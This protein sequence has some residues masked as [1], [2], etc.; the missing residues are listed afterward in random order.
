MKSYQ[1]RLFPTKDQIVQLQELSDIR[2]DIWNS[3]CDIQQKTYETKKSIL[4]KFDL[5]NLLPSL[6][7]EKEIMQEQALEIA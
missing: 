4:N 5:N 7:K 2:K 6:K 1:I 3:L